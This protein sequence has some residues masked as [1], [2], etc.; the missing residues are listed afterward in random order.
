MNFREFINQQ[1]INES[2]FTKTPSILGDLEKKTYD[3]INHYREVLIDLSKQSGEEDDDIHHDII[4]KDQNHISIIR[5]IAQKFSKIYEI[6]KESPKLKSSF[7]SDTT[8]EKVARYAKRKLG[9]HAD[10]IGDY[11]KK[12]NLMSVD[13]LYN[14]WKPGSWI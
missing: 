4:K 5:S 2:W 1:E 14:I 11:L 12:I 7:F 8:F 10:D 3:L 9:Y 13:R 6:E